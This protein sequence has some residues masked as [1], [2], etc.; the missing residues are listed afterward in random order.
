[1]FQTDLYDI[2]PAANA[3]AVVRGDRYRF[4]ILASQLIRIEWSEDGVFEDRPTRIALCRD[5]P[6]PAFTK[7]ETE[8]SLEI[9]T[10]HLH[11]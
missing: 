4:T 1:M 2:R 10:E 11:L 6:V 9:E 8:N 3:A 7:T 5:F